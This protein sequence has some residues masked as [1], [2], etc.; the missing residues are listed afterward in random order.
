MKEYSN[1]CDPPKVAGGALKM[2]PMEA[3]TISTLWPTLALEENG[4]STRCSV[5]MP[6]SM[7][8]LINS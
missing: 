5:S 7:I 1:V 6:V 8:C 4:S 2:L 3:G